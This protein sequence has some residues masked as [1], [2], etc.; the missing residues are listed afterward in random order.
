MTESLDPGS[1]RAEIDSL[2]DR[3]AALKRQLEQA[4]ADGDEAEVRRLRA[5]IEEAG[6]PLWDAWWM[7]GLREAAVALRY[8]QGEG[9]LGLDGCRDALDHLLWAYGSDGTGALEVVEASPTRVTLVGSVWWLSE[10]S[11]LLVEATFTYDQG[12]RAV[13]GIVVRAGDD[14]SDNPY[15]PGPSDEW[16]PRY[17][18]KYVAG[19]PE[20]DEQW[21]VVIRAS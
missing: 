9:W 5:L 20:R 16:S 10:R 19:R 18:A 2:R 1:M 12:S 14:H 13:T 6:E 4:R 17:W 21:D 3:V 7:P 15:P 11:G 8:K